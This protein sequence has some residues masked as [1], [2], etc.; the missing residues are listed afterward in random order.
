MGTIFAFGGK[1]MKLPSFLTKE[2]YGEIRLTGHR[3]GLLHVVDLFNEGNN[4][5]QIVAE[6]DSIDLPLVRQVIDFYLENKAEVDLY[7]AE[8]HAEIDR[9]AA[10]PRKGPDL[11]E[12]Q[13]RMDS[14][15]RSKGA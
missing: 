13:R 9:Q 6:F 1:V 3:I 14:L 5:E 15:R 8:C 10:Q 11:A 12:L 7:I 2:K 4:A